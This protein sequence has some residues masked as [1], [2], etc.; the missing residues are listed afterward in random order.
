MKQSIKFLVT[1]MM[2]AISLSCSDEDELDDG[3]VC[4]EC[5]MTDIK[6]N[7]IADRFPVCGEKTY[8]E[9]LI[10]NYENQ[11]SDLYNIECTRVK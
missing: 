8:V 11:S 5:I 2:C 3:Y 10:E 9:I 4:Y 1:L 6:T 7:E